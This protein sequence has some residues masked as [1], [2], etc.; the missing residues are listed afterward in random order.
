M[1]IQQETAPYRP[2][3]LKLEKWAEAAALCSIMDKIC[4]CFAS[5]DCEL[6]YANLS[7]EERQLAIG[8]SNA[9]TERKVSV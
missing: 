1:K 4:Q 6:T 3:T 7:A 2:I 9:F 5:E 8:I